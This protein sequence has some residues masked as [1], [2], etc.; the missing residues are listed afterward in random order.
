MH[1]TVVLTYMA[2]SRNK[3]HRS[4][5][6]AISS[7][8]ICSCSARPF[9]SSLRADSFYRWCS[10]RFKSE[11]PIDCPTYREI[12]IG[13][14]SSYLFLA[15]SLPSAQSIVWERKK[16]RRIR[17]RIDE[18][19]KQWC[20]KRAILAGVIQSALAI[21]WSYCAAIDSCWANSTRNHFNSTS[22]DFSTSRGI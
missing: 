22:I 5:G 10:Q 17:R 1:V 18:W 21:V 8:L 4:S 15:L 6:C 20:V 2:Y 12:E 9:I 11:P 16:R 3:S 13:P 19:F 14:F 7:N